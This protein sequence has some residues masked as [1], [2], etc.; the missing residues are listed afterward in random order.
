MKK[1]RVLQVF[2]GRLA[3][4]PVH[5]HPGLLFNPWVEGYRDHTFGGR[6]GPAVG[7]TNVFHELAHA[8]QFG[9]EQFTQRGRVDGFLFKVPKVFVYDRYC[10]EPRTSQATLRELETFAHQLHLMQAAG[11]KVSEEQFIAYS[12]KLMRFMPDWYHIP[13]KSE[14]ARADWCRRRIESY[15]AKLSRPE[16]LSRLEAWLDATWRRLR[17]SDAKTRRAYHR[18]DTRYRVEGQYEVSA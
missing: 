1:D 8:A 5:R 9:V 12:A 11:Y 13:G 7:A 18:V 15:Y 3:R 6:A 16:V 17:R 2:R 10:D 14:D 4:L